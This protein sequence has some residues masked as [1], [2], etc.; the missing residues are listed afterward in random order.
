MSNREIRGIICFIVTAI[1]A[2]LS[3][4]LAAVILSGMPSE[5]DNSG[6]WLLV[7]GGVCF[8]F[9]FAKLGHFE[10]F[11]ADRRSL[12]EQISD[13][14]FLNRFEGLEREAIELI[15]EQ[16]DSSRNTPKKV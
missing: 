8:S 15:I 9:V 3:S 6:M 12:C 11:V 7:S 10:L 13:E 1:L 4:A 5:R 14:S 2:L 16:M